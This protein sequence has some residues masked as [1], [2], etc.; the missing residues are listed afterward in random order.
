MALSVI[1]HEA[2]TAASPAAVYAL[3]ADGSTWP[4]WSPIGSF[5]LL[6]PGDG[7]PEGVGAVRMFHTGRV[8]SK[9]RVVTAKPN[10]TFA[11]ELVSGLAVREYHAVV[12]LRPGDG[13]TTIGWRSTFR[14]KVP[15]TGWLYRRQLG[16]FIAQTVKGLAE[17]A[18][19]S[20]L[21]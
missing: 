8:H 13:G 6:E 20:V 18:A 15:G 21:G 3:L 17:R 16:Q 14:A 2:T 19:G 12:T 5:E 7:T 1:E 11:Y 4:Q 9:E 10:E